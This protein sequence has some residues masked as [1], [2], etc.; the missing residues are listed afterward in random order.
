M[1]ERDTVRVINIHLQSNRLRNEEYTYVTDLADNNEERKRGL[2][3][4]MGNC[5]TPPVSVPCSR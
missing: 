2:L 4:I 5:A 3:K 1:I